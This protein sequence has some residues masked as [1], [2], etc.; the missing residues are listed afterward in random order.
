VLSL[1]APTHDESRA[2]GLE[3]VLRRLV[4]ATLSFLGVGYVL[5]DAPIILLL[6][7]ALFQIPISSQQNIAVLSGRIM[8]L[9]AAVVLALVG[10]LF[11]LSGVQFYERSSVRGVAFLSVLLSCFYLLCLGV[12]ATLLLSAI[13]LNTVLLILSP[14]LTMVGAAAYMVPSRRFQL[15]GSVLCVVSGV[16]L[17][18]GITS[19][20]VLDLAFGWGIPF[21]G[22][23]MSMVTLESVVVVVGPTAAFVNSVFSD[24]REH[25][26]LTHIFPLIVALVYGIG[27]FIGSLVLSFSFWDLIWKSPWGGPFHGLSNWAMSVVGFWS[28]SLVLLDV[29]GII[30][31][32]TSCL[33]FVFVAREYVQ[34]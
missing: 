8:F 11:I 9:M 12:G 10:F 34:L 14:I 24:R 6:A 13:A 23:F 5:V 32:V 3:S 2:T 1:T 27:L 4:L 19:T 7:Q 22:P 29:G 18:I 21:N 17:A 30:L 28:A 25:R 16:L 20:P 15:T 26:P 31:I 33:G